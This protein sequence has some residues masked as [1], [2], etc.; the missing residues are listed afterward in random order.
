MPGG[1][2]ENIINILYESNSV[3]FSQKITLKN[4]DFLLNMKKQ[5]LDSLW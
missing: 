2:L 4:L 5:Y 3:F 1:Q